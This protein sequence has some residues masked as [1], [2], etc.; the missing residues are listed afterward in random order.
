[1]QMTLFKYITLTILTLLYCL[2][3]HAQT[4]YGA[5]VGLNFATYNAKDL[6][7]A[8]SR[9]T[10]SKTGVQAGV[11]YNISSGRAFSLQPEVNYSKKGLRQETS[12]NA[13]IKRNFN[14]L[15][16]NLIGKTTIG[17]ENIK[18][19]LHLGPGFGYLMSAKNKN[20]VSGD[21]EID[22]DME[23]IRKWDTMIHV[24]LG[25]AVRLGF[26]NAVFLEGRYS[27]SVS[28]LYNI[29]DSLKPENYEATNHRV[30]SL[31]IGYIY[32]IDGF[33]MQ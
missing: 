12:D 13:I 6:I 23:N 25:T 18:G 20:S 4:G 21:T 24:G 1:M 17:N 15:E 5:R 7:G 26:E 19:F 14:Y 8:G 27:L 32:Y 28:D 3:V 9:T 2:N 31:T 11:F 10:T 29:E 33:E 30:F 16:L 22:L